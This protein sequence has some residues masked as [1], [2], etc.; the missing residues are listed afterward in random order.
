MLDEH[1]HLKCKVCGNKGTALL[2]YWSL[3]LYVILDF[4][5]RER[6][7]STPA[8][9]S[10]TL[11][12]VYSHVAYYVYIMTISIPVWCGYDTKLALYFF[13]FLDRIPFNVFVATDVCQ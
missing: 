4:K 7:F 1:W 9:A 11:C 12:T 10:P 3:Y 13:S 8:I 5:F 2:P 6:L